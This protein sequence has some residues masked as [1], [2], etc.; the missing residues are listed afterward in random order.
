M[1]DQEP[2]TRIRHRSKGRRSSNEAKLR[3]LSTH[4]TERVKELNCLYGISRLFENQ[5]LNLNQIFR[6][7][8]DIVPPA[9]QFPEV[10]CARI[11]LENKE[12]VSANF[13]ESAWSQK[14]DILVN[15]KCFGSIEVCYFEKRP[16]FD[17]GPF[18]KEERNL[19]YVI[20]ERLGHTVERKMA[21]DNVKLL[22]QRERDL[23]EQ[24]QA[25]MRIRIDFTRKLIHEL[26]TPLTALI[27][28]SQLLYDEMKDDRYGKL[29][30]Y[31]WDG[32]QNLNIRIEELHDVIRGEIG[33]LKLTLRPVNIK[34]L[35]IEVANETRALARQRGV[36]IVLDLEKELPEMSADPDRIRQVMLN[37]INN[38]LKYA[39]DSR[40]IKITASEKAQSV[41]IGVKDSGPGISEER[42]KTIFAPA[43]ELVHHEERSGGL[44]IGLALCKTLVE[45]HQG[46]IWVKS[47][48]GKG[49]SFFFTIPIR[50]SLI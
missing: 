7:V 14:Q 20:A 35:L 34:A 27:A 21:E 10:T 49:S 15:G 30:K 13:V 3:E 1:T 25:E 22:Y 48:I 28:T 11:K 42:Q 47:K 5:N 8:I 45:L 6:G 46:K 31:I 41:K 39:K 26:K 23:R 24:L 37:L 12:F 4:L 2:E 19:L 36:T 17:E 9:W 18:L 44:G 16:D 40:E 32:A 29:A 50:D 43:Y 38:A 33:T